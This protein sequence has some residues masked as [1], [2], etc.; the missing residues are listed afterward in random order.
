MPE[1]HRQTTAAGSGSLLPRVSLSILTDFA[2]GMELQRPGKH[3]FCTEGVGMRAA[4]HANRFKPGIRTKTC[5][6]SQTAN[7]N[8]DT[9]VLAYH[10]RWVVV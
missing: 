9:V 5:S 8:H 2:L 10:V 1:E 7:R 3:C 4:N 6:A